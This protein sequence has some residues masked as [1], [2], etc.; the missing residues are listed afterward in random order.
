MKFWKIVKLNEMAQPSYQETNGF[1]SIL[2]G[3]H[4]WCRWLALL[5]Q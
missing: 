1:R 5:F 3:A 2:A 4:S